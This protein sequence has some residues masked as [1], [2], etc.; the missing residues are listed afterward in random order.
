MVDDLVLRFLLLTH[1]PI[2]LLHLHHHVLYLVLAPLYFLLAHFLLYALLDRF[3]IH[4]DVVGFSQLAQL[5][6]VVVLA[7]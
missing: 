5:R 3:V 2:F 6:V 4:F 1:L 7:L